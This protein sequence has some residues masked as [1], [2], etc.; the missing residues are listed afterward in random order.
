MTQADVSSLLNLRYF[1]DDLSC[2][3][4]GVIV[5]PAKSVMP[6]VHP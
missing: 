2:K 6:A 1:Y 5:K 4:I 3:M